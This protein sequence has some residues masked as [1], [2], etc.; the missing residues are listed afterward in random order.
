MDTYSFQVPGLVIWTSH[1]IFGVYFFWLGYKML[2]ER[3]MRVHG[4]II[5]V[6]GA[7]MALYHLHVWA[8]NAFIKNK[9]Y[10]Q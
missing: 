3:K 1:I 5:L 10:I 7:L 9:K 6:L 8:H 2:D 4:V